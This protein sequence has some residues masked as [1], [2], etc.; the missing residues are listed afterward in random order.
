[1]Y[2]RISIV[3]SLLVLLAVFPSKISAQ[4]AG[5]IN[6][7]L[8]HPSPGGKEWVEFYVSDSNG[9]K[10][11]WIDDDTSFTEDSGGSVKKSLETLVQ[12]NDDKHFFIELTGS[13]FN[14]TED[15]VVLFNSEG[16]IVDQIK[17]T[18][19]PGYDV[20]F[21]RTP[22]GTGSFYLLESATK[23]SPN[24]GQ[25]PAPT[26]P[27][28]PT[29]KPT[30][31]ISSVSIS[32]PQEVNTSTR[33]ASSTTDAN[34]IIIPS[35]TRSVL[36]STPRQSSSSARTASQGAFPTAILGANTT[37]EPTRIPLPSLPVNVQGVSS[38]PAL[39]TILGA[40]FII[41][42][43]VIVFVRKIRQKV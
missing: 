15:M 1:M 9:V 3:I 30:K 42:C 39:F 23:G 43:G 11:Y 38:T 36:S 22:D 27:P 31:A 8:V 32:A 18:D 29:A 25:K 17:Y 26:D 14:N 21:G 20:T 33:R 12:G 37:S 13:M 35:A 6:E 41:A 7:V 24:S 28:E 40:G 16:V 10:T 4:S 2:S 19:G 34:T 5:V